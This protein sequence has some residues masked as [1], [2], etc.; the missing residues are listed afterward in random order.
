MKKR[1]YISKALLTISLMLTTCLQSLA[2]NFEVDGIYYNVISTTEKTA[3][4][5]YQGAEYYYYE[6]EYSGDIVIPPTVTVED[7]TFSVIGIDAYTFYN[8]TGVTSISIPKT[9]VMPATVT[10]TA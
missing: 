8:C 5:T 7:I 1:F 4:V 2:H 3:Y 9:I 6:N 10:S